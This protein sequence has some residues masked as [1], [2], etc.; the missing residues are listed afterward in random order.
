MPP[1]AP[2]TEEEDEG[3][4]LAPGTDSNKR[5]KYIKALE[6]VMDKL[7]ARAEVDLSEIKP[8]EIL[9]NVDVAMATYLKLSD[10]DVPTPQQQAGASVT[11]N[12]LTREQ[13][14]QMLA[15]HR[16]QTD[17]IT[18]QAWC[19]G[20]TCNEVASFPQW[21]TWRRFSWWCKE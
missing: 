13:A 19:A 10:R 17:K 21:N 9:Y 7:L 11:V 8:R 14:L 20:R 18:P 4:K 2:V 5:K 1:K 12:G 3:L 15:G 16:E 6:K